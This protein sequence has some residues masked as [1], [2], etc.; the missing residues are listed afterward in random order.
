MKANEIAVNFTQKPITKAEYIAQFLADRKV[1]AVFTLSGGMIAFIV[2]AIYSLGQTPIIGTRHEQAA[3]FAAET[4]AR[5]SNIPTVALA[6]SGPGAS[7]LITAVASSFFDSVPTIYITGQVNQSEM[8]KSKFQRQNGFQE[9]DI[10]EAVKGIT[11]SAIKVNS[12]S[13]LHLVLTKAWEIATND[14]PGPVLI[15]IPIDVQQEHFVNEQIEYV[16]RTHKKSYKKEVKKLS[17]LLAK[18]SNPLILA[19][20][21]LVTAN[22]IN[23]FR[24]LVAKLKIPVVHSL[25]AVDSL[26]SDSKYRIGMIGSYGNKEANYA[27][28][29]SDL[30][31]CLGSRLDVRQIGSD[32]KAFQQNKFIYRV[33]IDDSEICGRVKASKSI[34]ANLSH[35]ITDWI[36]F[37]KAFEHDKWIDELH[38][39]RLNNPQQADQDKD[40]IWFP[41]D[42]LKQISSI[43]KDVEGYI[44]D[45][46]QHQM[47]AAQSLI[48]S[49]KQK[50]VTSGGLGAMG[51][52]IPSAIGA[53]FAKRGNWVVIAGD[54][55]TQLSLAELQTIKELN[56]P[57]SIFVINNN[58]HGMVAQFQEANLGNRLVLT[59][60]G[61]ST[62]DF[63]KI[64]NAFGIPSFSVSNGMELAEIAGKSNLITSGP[65]LVEIKIS[66]QARAL[67]KN[68]W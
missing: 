16:S 5:V 13:N 9:L 25:M 37:Y 46:G 63:V 68:K 48:L 24:E 23:E 42:I 57:I 12:K 31:I 1:P 65:V 21:G 66:N 36:S 22:V 40:L 28:R 35:F 52:A 33:D 49:A 3:G 61:Y 4:S 7:N 11:K 60:E 59:R 38:L 29:N 14:R 18:S 45:V 44:V 30:L 56:L 10:V 51:F 58:Q 43:C 15:D 8:K 20:G 64:G 26:P 47:W 2:D 67:P 32:I 53:C 17:D 50:F 39:Y 34:N 27:L 62:P 41:N 19:G 55:C 6:T 54:G